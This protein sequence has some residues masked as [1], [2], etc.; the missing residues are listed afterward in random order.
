M[1]S[2]SKSGQWISVGT[3]ERLDGGGTAIMFDIDRS[4]FLSGFVIKRGDQVYAYVNHC[5]H[6]GSRLDWV[7]GELFD[8]SGEHLICATHGAIFEP[9]TGKCVGGP[10][11]NQ[12]LIPMAVKLERNSIYV[13]VPPRYCCD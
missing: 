1:S 2:P 12:T 8:E 3:L 11:I 5:P 9:D 10:C 7:P 4:K 6:N 13:K